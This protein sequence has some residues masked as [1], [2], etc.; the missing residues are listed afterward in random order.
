MLLPR[1]LPPRFARHLL[2]LAAALAQLVAA[3]GA[4]LPVA[5]RPS[6]ARADVAPADPVRACGAG[7]CCC[8]PPAGEAVCGCCAP[9]PRTDAFVWVGGS[10][11]NKCNDLPVS[12]GLLKFEFLA[13]APACEA[14]ALP[15]PGGALAPAAP[16][17]PPRTAAEPPVPP[18]KLP[19][20]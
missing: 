20:M 7:A 15:V 13:V 10:F 3:T 18:P 9:A 5:P 4:P 12:A 16:P 1:L 6:D 11:Q 19:V 17:S 8:A 2:A 14:V